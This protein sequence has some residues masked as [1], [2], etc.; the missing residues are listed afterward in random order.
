MVVE[1]LLICPQGGHRHHRV[2][3]STPIITAPSQAAEAAEADSETESEEEEQVTLH[4]VA[5][6]KFFKSE[7]ALHNHER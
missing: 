6:D 2:F 1:V 7:R 4:C 5:C 3:V